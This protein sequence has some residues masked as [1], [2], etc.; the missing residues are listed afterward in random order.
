VL[1]IHL[2]KWGNTKN[3]HLN[4]LRIFNQSLL[5]FINLFDS[6]LIL[7]PQYNTLNL[8]INAFSSGLLGA[9]FRKKEVESAITVGQCTSALSSKFPLSQ[10]N[11]EALD[12]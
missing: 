7:M 3:F 2:A 9:R 11:A 1:L 12:R 6:R 10:R 4:A 5:D 8:V